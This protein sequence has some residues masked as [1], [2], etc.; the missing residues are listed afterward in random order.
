MFS[1]ISVHSRGL[2]D[3]FSGKIGDVHSEIRDSKCFYVRSAPVEGV[4][5]SPAEEYAQI[6][7]ELII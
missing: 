2:S 3:Y 6:M 1:P 7:E 5:F 4:R